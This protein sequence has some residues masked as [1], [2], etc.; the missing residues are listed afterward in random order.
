MKTRCSGSDAPRVT[1][2]DAP[3]T[4][5]ICKMETQVAREISKRGIDNRDRRSR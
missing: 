1:K 5:T 2:V 4:R 3:Q